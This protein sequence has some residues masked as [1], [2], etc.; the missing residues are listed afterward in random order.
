L[1][2]RQRLMLRIINVFSILQVRR[3]CDL[4]FEHSFKTVDI[5]VKGNYI[6]VTMFRNAEDSI[7][8]RA[9]V[10]ERILR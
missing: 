6:A 3:S 10:D 4:K 1:R 7:L 5:A 9:P 8:W 2:T